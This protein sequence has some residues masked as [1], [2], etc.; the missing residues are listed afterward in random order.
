MQRLS[1]DT[2]TTLSFATTAANNGTLYEAVFT[3]SIG[4]WRPPTAAML[5]VQF[6]P[7]ITMAP[8]NDTVTVGAT[9]TLS[10]QRP[11]A[12]RRQ[13]CNGTTALTTGAAL[14][15]AVQRA[16]TSTTLNFATTATDNGN[17][18]EAVF[19]N[20]IGSATTTAA[21]LDV[22][23]APS[24][25]MAPSNDTVTAGATA[26]FTAAASGNPVP[27]VQWYD[28]TDNGAT[29]TALSAATPSPR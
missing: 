28:S 22:Q 27:A 16:P 12:T 18:Y 24:I 26:T 4:S 10:R 17:L 25:T 6:E 15:R 21:T 5:D 23:F 2:S 9:A 29:Y 11:P 3:N 20:S 13:R 19:T 7:S 8:S 1:G 14:T